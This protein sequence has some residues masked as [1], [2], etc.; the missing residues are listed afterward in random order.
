[1]ISAAAE[2]VDIEMPNFGDEGFPVA[3]ELL[4]E[5][6]HA[7]KHERR[8]FQ[9][10]RHVVPRHHDIAGSFAPHRP[11]RIDRLVAIAVVTELQRRIGIPRRRLR[12]VA[13]TYSQ[14][15][16]DRERSH[17]NNIAFS[18]RYDRVWSPT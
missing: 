3:A 15:D 11:D 4:V 8:Q 1:M 5:V 7:L 13:A 16:E 9:H 14:C 12:A 10:H 2:P 18:C 17:A 6:A